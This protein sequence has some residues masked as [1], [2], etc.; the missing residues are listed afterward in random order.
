MKKIRKVERRGRKKK[1]QEK[2]PH[3]QV[4]FDTDEQRKKF[5]GW[6]EIQK[7]SKKIARKKNLLLH[8]KE[9]TKDDVLLAKIDLK[10]AKGEKISDADYNR[11]V[12]IMSQRVE[13]LWGYYSYFQQVLISLEL[14]REGLSDEDREALV[15]ENLTLIMHK[16]KTII[17]D[18]FFIISSQ[19]EGGYEERMKK[20]YAGF[21][22]LLQTKGKEHPVL[23]HFLGCL[24]GEAKKYYRKGLYAKYTL[25]R[26]ILEQGLS[27]F[28]E[29]I[30]FYNFV[31]HAY[32]QQY[33]R[34]KIIKGYSNTYSK[35]L[36]Y[37][38]TGRCLKCGCQ[39]K[40]IQK[41]ESSPRGKQRYKCPNCEKSHSNF[42]IF[43]EDSIDR[44][45]ETARGE[46]VPLGA[47]LFD[48]HQEDAR[49][50]MDKE[51]TQKLLL[52]CA[53]KGREREF[54]EK[55]FSG[56]RQVDIAKE[57][58]CNDSYVSRIRGEIIDRAREK[59]DFLR[60]P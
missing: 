8:G 45:I 23:K 40:Y 37:C 49:D 31:R 59:L 60:K 5:I 42:D 48:R 17:P 20:Y 16:L 36:G 26:L 35:E 47:V 1:N 43:Q 46:T 28:I 7:R 10:K 3:T 55:T 15:I 22:N 11:W 53:K 9:V 39:S 34:N 56:C 52:S 30:K 51:S 19:Q 41:V 18:D 21:V 4:G 33:I 38:V 44:L 25:G 29:G 27:Y 54:I 32:A 14:N 58:G 12:N 6:L 50:K 2:L 57:W 13:D 24:V